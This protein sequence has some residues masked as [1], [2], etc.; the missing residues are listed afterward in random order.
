[1]SPV[2][3]NA[4]LPRHRTRRCAVLSR[5]AADAS[6][7][8]VDPSPLSRIGSLSA[9]RPLSVTRGGALKHVLTSVAICGVCGGP[10]RTAY[11][12]HGARLYICTLAQHVGWNAEKL[13]EYIQAAA[14][15]HLG[16]RDTVA[17]ANRKAGDGGDLVEKAS[18]LRGR[19]GSLADA[20][21]DGELASGQVKTSNA[22]ILSPLTQTDWQL[23]EMEGASNLA[24]LLA[25]ANVETSWERPSVAAK[26]K[27]IGSL[28]EVV[29]N[30]TGRGSRFKLG[31]ASVFLTGDECL[32]H[33]SSSS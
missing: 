30:P 14:N 11:T 31:A 20:F 7:S 21:V 25:A 8:S 16:R 3:R 33:H 27:A 18:T 13:E 9:R 26:R 19:L 23:I 29:I 6:C 5:T 1:M 28:M 32:V 4:A 10:A 12:S 2:V 22:R 24:P 17:L 15:L